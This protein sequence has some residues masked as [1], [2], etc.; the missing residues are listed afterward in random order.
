MITI[1]EKIRQDESI[2]QML[3]DICDVEV[4]AQISAL[5]EANGRLTLSQAGQIFARE[6]SGSKYILFE[7]GSVGLWGSEGECGRIADS[8]QSFF[9]LMV[10]CP[11]WRDYIRR[12]VYCDGATLQ[13][14]AEK[15]FESH[16]EMAQEDLELDL[17]AVQKQLAQQLGITLHHDIAQQVLMPFYK[18]AT[19]APQ[20]V[21]MFQEKD[22]SVSQSSGSLFK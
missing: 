4:F 13:Q 2:A 15:T 7:D 6:G 18:S 9:E 10:N 5:E 8:L 11:F 16:C 22:G 21:A 14:F 12:D 17:P 1:L 20:I 3:W 19:R